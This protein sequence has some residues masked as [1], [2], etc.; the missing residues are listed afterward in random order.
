M[1]TGMCQWVCA[2]AA[3]SLVIAGCD[4]GHGSAPDGGGGG[5]GASGGS[6]GNDAGGA[7]PASCGQVRPCGGDVVGTWAFLGVCL[8]EAES[9]AE[10]A[11]SCPGASVSDYAHTKSG[12]LTLNAD[13]TYTSNVVRETLSSV[14]TKPLNCESALDCASLSRSIT[15]TST[16]TCT[17]T[18]TCICRNDWVITNAVINGTYSVEGSRITLYMAQSS[19]TS[20]YCVE[21]DLLHQIG[22]GILAQPSGQPSIVSDAVSQRR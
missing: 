2:L 4:G 20:S 17:G 10:L 16:T 18:T 21:G 15:P 9:S 14:H 6:G 19:V 3:S 1:V 13:L 8:N 12:F 7:P 22:L 11:A 5:A